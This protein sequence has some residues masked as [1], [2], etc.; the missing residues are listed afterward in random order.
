VNAG[1]SINSIKTNYTPKAYKV[2]VYAFGVDMSRGGSSRGIK[3]GEELGAEIRHSG[4]HSRSR[5]EVLGFPDEKVAAIPRDAGGEVA[6]DEDGGLGEEREAAGGDGIEKS[7]QIILAEADII[8]IHGEGDDFEA[9]RVEALEDGGLLGSE[10]H[11]KSVAEERCEDARRIANLK[12]QIS[13]EGHGGT[14]T[15]RGGKNARD[16]NRD[17]PSPRLRRGVDWRSR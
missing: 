7:C 14:E 6:V 17:P 5:F 12:S 15:Q 3:R 16:A 1:A 9:Q 11:G 10:I 8:R 13:E 4:E 2:L